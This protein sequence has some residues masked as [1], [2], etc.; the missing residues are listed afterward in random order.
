MNKVGKKLVELG[1]EHFSKSPDR[2]FTFAETQV[3]KNVILHM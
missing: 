2:I 3:L 1:V